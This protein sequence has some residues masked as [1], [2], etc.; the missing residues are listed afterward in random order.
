M[1]FSKQIKTEIKKEVFYLEGKINID[2]NYFIKKIEDGI[3][4][5]P[6]NYKTNVQGF[7]TAWDYF[8]EDK[9]FLKIFLNIINNFEHHSVVFQH[10][11]KWKLDSCWGIK[12]EKGSYTKEHD[13][14]PAVLSGVIYLN[15]VKQELI[16]K[17]LN[18]KVAPEKGKFV[19]FSPILKHYTERNL[20]E[21]SKYG[22]SFNLM[23]DVL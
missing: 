8:I 22:L 15:D 9:K 11:P 7:M 5:S 3:I 14:L 21:T 1:N 16:F 2:S 10:L 13:H 6:N 19:I 4:N 20:E 18:I 23:P 17:E 12:E